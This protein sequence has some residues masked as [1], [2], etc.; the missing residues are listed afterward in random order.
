MGILFD[1][2]K[3]LSWVAAGLLAGL[4]LMLAV[5]GK[6]PSGVTDWLFALLWCGL[7]AFPGLLIHWVRKSLAD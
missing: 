5:I 6:G 4:F 7:L 1:I 2:L 3:L